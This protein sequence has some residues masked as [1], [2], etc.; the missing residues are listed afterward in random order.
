MADEIEV[1]NHVIGLREALQILFTEFAMRR[2]ILIAAWLVFGVGFVDLAR[3]GQVLPYGY[4]LHGVPISRLASPT[5]HV[6]VLLFLATDCPISNRYVPEI[7][8]LEKEFLGRGVTFWHV[9]PNATETSE[10]VLRHQTA[11]GLGGTT[12]IHPLDRLM[13]MAAAKVTPEAIVLVHGQTSAEPEMLKA[14]YTGRIDDRYL[15]IGRERPKATRHD[16]EEAINAMLDG[17]SVAPPQGAPVGCG[18]VSEAALQS[19]VGKR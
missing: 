4:D 17:R 2:A 8:R 10:G 11:Y 13:T 7:Q 14:V 3:G 12:L 19:G 16:L 15:D 9:Y 5:T 1:G 18:I 6:V